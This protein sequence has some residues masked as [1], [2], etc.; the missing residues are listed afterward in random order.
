MEKTQLA[1][2]IKGAGLTQDRVA[3]ALGVTRQTVSYWSRTGSLSS[4]NAAAL[5]NLLKVPIGTLL[6]DEAEDDADGRIVRVTGAEPVREG[7]IRVPVFDAAGSCGGGGV[8]SDLITG[9]LDLAAWFVRSLPGVVSANHLQVISSTGD[10]MAPT[11]EPHAML[12]IDAAQNRIG[13]DG[14]YCLRIAGDLFIKRVQKN[15]GGTLTLLSDNPHYPPQPLD[16]PAVEQTQVLG[17]VVY[18]F[19]GRTI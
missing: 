15:P 13:G 3:E 9:A 1:K 16:A 14:I 18:A 4:R 7:Y 8:G 11:I 10:S 19:N 5:S 2:L 17:R 6:G 12:L